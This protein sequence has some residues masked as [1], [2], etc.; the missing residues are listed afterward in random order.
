[1]RRRIARRSVEIGGMKDGMIHFFLTGSWLMASMAQ[2]SF[3]VGEVRVQPLGAYVVRIEQRGPKGFEDRETF[4]ANP[5]AF[6]GTKT[7]KT[8]N[9]I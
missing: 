9:Y 4:T 2:A 1:M 6:E 7:K 8:Q 3:V 5:G